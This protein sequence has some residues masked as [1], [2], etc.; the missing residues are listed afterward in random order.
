MSQTPVPTPVIPPQIKLTGSAE[1]R[2]RVY[3]QSAQARIERSLRNYKSMFESVDLPW[4]EAVKRAAPFE[5]IIGRTF[6]VIVDELHGVAAGCGVDFGALLALNCR[7][8]LL[9]ANYLALVSRPEG[10]R[11]A[12]GGQIN[13]CTSFAV[14]DGEAN[15]LLAQNWDWVG[16]QRESLVM[17]DQRPAS[18][19]AHLT[20][21]EAGMMAK[22][23]FN[24]HGLGVTLNILRSHEDGRQPGMPVHALLRGL[25]DCTSLDEALELG[26]SLQYCGSS[27]VLLADAGGAIASLECSPRGAVALRPSVSGQRASLCH[28][29]HFCDPELALIDA[30]VAGNLSTTERL[31]KAL[32]EIHTVHDV[33]TAGIL[34][35]DTS[36]GLTSI[37]RFPD[38]AAA[39]AAR[40][41][42]VVST[43]MDLTARELHISAAQPSVTPYVRVALSLSEMS[44]G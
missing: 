30:S 40:V 2:G 11:P 39:P 23:G 28:T 27:N 33:A 17:L 4:D 31:E 16:A 5:E 12:D 42:T 1:D 32:Q 7:T 41:E 43:I 20:V 22:I 9:P 26:L 35:S 19:P 37:C 14:A 29:N 3:G 36:A 8:E 21:A 15:V 6:P 44:D 38:P 25:L 34:L 10:Q 13:E 18:G 24:E